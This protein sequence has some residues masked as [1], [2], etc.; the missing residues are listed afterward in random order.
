[1]P[2]TLKT[3]HPHIVRVEGVCGGQPIIDGLRITVDQV[4]RLHLDG[5]SPEE[6]TRALPLTLGQIFDALSYYHDHRSEIDHMIARG[7]E[8]HAGFFKS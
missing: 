6:I 4:V 8:A 7:N 2:A 1:M 5:A 3:E